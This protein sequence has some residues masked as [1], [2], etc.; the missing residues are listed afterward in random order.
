[1]IFL[2]LFLNNLTYFNYYCFNDPLF[3]PLILTKKL[4]LLSEIKVL[5]IIDSINFKN[6]FLFINKL[7]SDNFK[8]N[9]FNYQIACNNLSFINWNN[10]Q[11]EFLNK[12]INDFESFIE[13]ELERFTKIFINKNINNFSGVISD[14]LNFSDILFSAIEYVAFLSSIFAFGS[15]ISIIQ[16]L[17]SLFKYISP[18]KFVTNYLNIESKDNKF[19]NFEKN[20]IINEMQK[21]EQK[22]VFD[23]INIP[24]ENIPYYRWINKKILYFFLYSLNIFYN[25]YGSIYQ[26]CLDYLKNNYLNN[27]DQDILFKQN[28]QFLILESMIKFSNEI[29]LIIENKFKNLLKEKDIKILKNLLPLSLNTTSAK[30]YN[31]FLKWVIRES[32]PD[33]GLWSIRE[34]SSIDK[35]SSNKIFFDQ[36]KIFFPL[37]IHIL[38]ISEILFKFF[39]ENFYFYLF[40]E[41]Y[42][43]IYKS[44]FDKPINIFEKELLNL[45]E[46]KD[47]NSI[48]SF[49]N[50]RYLDKD[51]LSLQDI[52]QNNKLNND[53]EKIDKLNIDN[54]N[55]ENINKKIKTN[56][57]SV[58]K[59]SIN[60]ILQNF[61]EKIIKQEPEFI[62]KKLN[63]LGEKELIDF[64]I[65][66]NTYK[67]FFTNSFK[68]K[69]IFLNKK[70]HLKVITD[71]YS[72]FNKDDPL[73]FD[74][75]ISIIRSPILRKNRNL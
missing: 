66:L 56:I 38:K 68:R 15:R 51:M 44:Y 57:C 54:E 75:P 71:F 24:F 35:N 46:K 1:M 58:N 63:F 7:S 70:E 65:Y 12:I 21:I 39:L 13:E 48:I 34:K 40:E 30:R 29:F 52:N 10:S 9:I 33:L 6:N 49:I 20:N 14:N 11:K 74:L 17:N 69:S 59:F 5:K 41:E 8:K 60:I 61:F 37:D 55:N 4:S 22:K 2:K 72:I 31:L 53:I 32:F 50:L 26:F 25:K 43:K 16:F 28:N 47:Y 42:H 64:Y 18:F 67:E 73:I 19:I 27:Y 3:F 36:K 45:F 62:L 23:K